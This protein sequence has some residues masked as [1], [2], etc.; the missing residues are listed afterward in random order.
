MNCSKKNIYSINLD[1]AVKSIP[2]KPIIDI[3]DTHEYRKVSFSI[4]KVMQDY[5]LGPNGAI[6]TAL[7]LFTA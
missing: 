2:Y 1:P 5:Q 7:N 4:S 6:L 3:R